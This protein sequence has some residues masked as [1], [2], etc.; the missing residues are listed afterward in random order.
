MSPNDYEVAAV[1]EALLKSLARVMVSPGAL[2]QIAEAV[3]VSL[4]DQDLRLTSGGKT[5]SIDD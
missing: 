4:H 1:R 3:V 2:Q 5:P